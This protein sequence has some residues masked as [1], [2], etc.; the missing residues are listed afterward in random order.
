[1]RSA[2]ANRGWFRTASQ[3]V[4]NAGNA[5]VQRSRSRRSSASPGSK[6]PC[7]TLGTPPAIVPASVAMPPTWKNGS[8]VQKTSPSAKRIRSAISSPWATIAPCR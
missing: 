3:I 7:W 6:K 2:S 4:S 1:M 8:G 5:T